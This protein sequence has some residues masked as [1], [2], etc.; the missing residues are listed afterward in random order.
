MTGQARPAAPVID[1]G[2]AGREEDRT[3]TTGRP[4]SY[5]DL[6]AWERRIYAAVWPAEG[7][8]LAVPS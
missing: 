8:V 4:A 1:T 2:T 7:R 6:P 5:R 3:T